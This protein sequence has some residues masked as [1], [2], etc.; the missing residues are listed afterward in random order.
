MQ[1]N[2]KENV[3][4]VISSNVSK[5]AVGQGSEAHEESYDDDNDHQV[6]SQYAVQSSERHR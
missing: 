6:I 1:C 4:D 3:S 2:I 5:G